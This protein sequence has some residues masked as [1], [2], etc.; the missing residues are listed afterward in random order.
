MKQFAGLLA[1]LTPSS[2]ADFPIESH[3]SFSLRWLREIGGAYEPIPLGERAVLLCDTFGKVW[4][5]KITGR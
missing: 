3:P 5:I 2:K 4:T 1:P